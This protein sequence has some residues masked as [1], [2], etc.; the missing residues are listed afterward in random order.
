MNNTM[1]SQTQTILELGKRHLREGNKI[2]ISQILPSHIFLNVIASYLYLE[3]AWG[4]MSSRKEYLM[5]FIGAD[6]Y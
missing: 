4:F 5:V 6:F 2:L 3:L 1:T